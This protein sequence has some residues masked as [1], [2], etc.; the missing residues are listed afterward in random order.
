MGSLIFSDATHQVT[1]FYYLF[2]LNQSSSSLPFPSR[3]ALF[4]I[5]CSQLPSC[6]PT[7]TVQQK[8]H[9]PISPCWYYP[10]I[11]KPDIPLAGLS[12]VYISW[13]YPR[14]TVSGEFTHP[15]R[16]F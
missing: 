13:Y 11:Y 9:T 12:H 16:C 5:K 3:S 6:N 2:S 4:C 8:R 10:H 15:L 7:P 14:D 1:L